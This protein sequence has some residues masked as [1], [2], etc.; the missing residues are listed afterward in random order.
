MFASSQHWTIDGQQLI[1]V[2]QPV[3]QAE[4][5]YSLPGLSRIRTA[6]KNIANSKNER[7]LNMKKEKKKLVLKIPDTQ[8]KARYSL[9]E[10]SRLRT[11]MNNMQIRKMS[12]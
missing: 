12:E 2:I 5:R 7:T 8:A 6:M 10:M 3:T 9:P 1:A 4:A 11:A